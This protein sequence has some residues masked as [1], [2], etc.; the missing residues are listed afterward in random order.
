MFFPSCSPM[1]WVSVFVDLRTRWRKTTGPAETARHPGRLG[2]RLWRR[3]LRRNA[4]ERDEAAF[5][6]N[7]WS[8]ITR[9]GWWRSR[10]G[11]LGDTTRVDTLKSTAPWGWYPAPKVLT[12]KA[13]EKVSDSNNRKGCIAFQPAFFSEA[14]FNFGG[15]CCFLG[16]VGKHHYELW[17]CYCI[18]D[19]CV[20]Y[21]PNTP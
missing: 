10:R 6:S 12:A 8:L 14:T 11:D 2:R 18:Y 16:L 19:I 1:I 7:G 17:L 5:A 21:T 20:I 15:C 4:W 13:P 9:V 3:P